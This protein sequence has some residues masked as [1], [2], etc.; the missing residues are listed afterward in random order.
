V[1][2]DSRTTTATSSTEKKERK[3]E[4]KKEKPDHSTTRGYRGYIKNSLSLLINKKKTR[5]QKQ[6]AWVG[7]VART[8][9]DPA[10]RGSHQQ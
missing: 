7:E 5:K 1:S 8:M 4:R 10:S 2:S 9:G 3:K 6:N